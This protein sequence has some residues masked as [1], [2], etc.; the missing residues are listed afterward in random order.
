M[1]R[2]I[3]LKKFP[4][5]CGEQTL[6]SQGCNPYWLH[7]TQC[8]ILASTNNKYLFMNFILTKHETKKKKAYATNREKWYNSITAN[9]HRSSKDK[10]SVKKTNKQT[11]KSYNV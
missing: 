10:L 7:I 2:T 9:N 4:D 5:I 6:Q 3:E 8:E 1:I 11:N